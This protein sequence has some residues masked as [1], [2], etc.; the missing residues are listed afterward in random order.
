MKKSIVLAGS[1]GLLGLVSQSLP[2]TAT[3]ALSAQA[4]QV[5]AE[6]SLT[7]AQRQI[8]PGQNPVTSV[9]D[10]SD[11]QPGI[12]YYD[13]IVN[14]VEKYQ[15]V[16]GYP[17]GTFRP[18]RSISRAEMAVLLNNCLE[19][20]AINQE[21]IE[22]IKALQEEFAAELA[23]LRG[24]V[25]GLEAQVKTLEAQQFSTTTKL[26]AEAV[27]AGQF[28]DFVN[29]PANVALV[30]QLNG[31]VE[32]GGVAL[33]DPAATGSS[34]R[35]SAIAR[36]RL[37]FNTSFNGDDLLTTQLQVGNGGQDFFTA[38]GLQGASN[39]IPVGGA[40]FPDNPLGTVS[41]VDL[42]AADYAGIGSTVT[43]RRL[44]YSFKPFGK[45][46][47]LTAGTNLLPSDF[48]DFNSYANNSAQDFSSGFF[49]NNPLIITN[50]VDF[51]GGAGGA[52]DWN[53]GGGPISIRG[54]YVAAAAANAAGPV[55]PGT[56]TV[57]CTPSFVGACPG[58]LGNDPHQATAEIEFADNLGSNGS[59]A[60]RLQYTFAET[61]NVQQ[62]VIGFNGEA[63]LGK[64]GVFG[65][66]GISIDPG[67]A[68]P[69]GR[70]DL[71]PGSNN[72]Q[73]WQGGL[74]LRDLFVPGSLLAVAAGQPFLA[75]GN[76]G[77]DQINFEAFYRFPINNNI[78]LTPAVM[79]IVNPFNTP[80]GLSAQGGNDNDIIQGVLRATFSF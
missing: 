45:D 46:L 66:Y 63:T 40:L 58:G 59:F 38:A 12:W 74:G 70:V 36:V 61:F 67:L 23:T 50:P 79:Y 60:A 80:N 35:A 37:N 43:L 3:E 13:A 73:T 27:L 48:V 49:I 8:P 54:V 44:A 47:T 11:I 6:A 9:D 41:L 30:P 62:N 64:F 29:N 15:C 14:L 75:T 28:G 24:R 65:R 69:G 5:P 17:D 16:A 77:P 20:V 26:Q 57:S 4:E 18:Q 55:P 53:P 32:A 71:L 39:P 56:G 21:D 25:D 51:N 72:V 52:F 31:D 22:T 34:S 78:T 76:P 68:T 19:A 2:A 1:L 7:L 42:G 33:L 10:L